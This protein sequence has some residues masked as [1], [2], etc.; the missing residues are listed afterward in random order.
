M[1]FIFERLLLKFI[2]I[3]KKYIFIKKGAPKNNIPILLIY[4]L[5]NK[6]IKS[7]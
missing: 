3:L 6:K 5:E 2:K 1:Y 4:Y 7:Y